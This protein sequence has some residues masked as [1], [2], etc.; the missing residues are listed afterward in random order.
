[1]PEQ[2]GDTTSDLT[3]LPLS[4]DAWKQLAAWFAWQSGVR[5]FSRHTLIAYQNDISEYFVFLGR[6]LGKEVTLTDLKNL[7]IRDLRSWLAAR[8]S[9]DM[10]ATS[11]ARALS[12]VRGFFRYLK[13]NAGLDNPAPF[14]LRTPKLPKPLPK[15]LSAD[16]SLMSMDSIAELDDEPWIGKRDIALLA[17][18]YGCGLRIG[19]ALSLKAGEFGIWSLESG[20]KKASQT[21]NPKLQTHIKSNSTQ[22]KARHFRVGF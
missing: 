19:E 1:M 7:E 11:N 5:R 16:E 2:L 21:L 3:G 12:T 18:L 13:K 20:E 8:V 14:N 15:A 10:S 9:K 22:L 4:Q 17:L 6:H